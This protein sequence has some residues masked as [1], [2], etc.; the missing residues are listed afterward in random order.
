MSDILLWTPTH[1][2]ASV[3]WVAR[4]YLH[5]LCADT[6]CNLEELTGGWGMKKEK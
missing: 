1:G 4:T 6:V 5:H 3:G 2:Y